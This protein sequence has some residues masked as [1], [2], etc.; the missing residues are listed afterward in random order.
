MVEA[1]EK[2]SAMMNTTQNLLLHLKKEEVFSREG[3]EERQ[4]LP[5]SDQ[6]CQPCSPLL[7]VFLEVDSE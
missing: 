7:S 4:E 6:V 1:T 2:A 3:D 5:W